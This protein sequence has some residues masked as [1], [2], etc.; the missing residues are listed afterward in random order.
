[1]QH[2]YTPATLHVIRPNYSKYLHEFVTLVLG[3]LAEGSAWH[4]HL[5]VHNAHWGIEGTQEHPQV[6]AAHQ[7]DHGMKRLWRG[8]RTTEIQSDYLT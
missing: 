4:G 6:T 1:M 7:V 3:S 2:T 5:A 8:W